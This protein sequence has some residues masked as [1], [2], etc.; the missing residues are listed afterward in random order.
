MLLFLSM[1]LFRL[2]RQKKYI[3]KNVAVLEVGKRVSHVTKSEWTRKKIYLRKLDN[4]LMMDNVMKW[5]TT[6]ETITLSET[7]TKKK[8]R[9][10]PFY[11]SFLLLGKFVAQLDSIMKFL[12]LSRANIISIHC[13][14]GMNGAQWNERRKTA[15]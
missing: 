14:N 8:Q 12:K 10:F 13:T 9:Y 11:A 4:N 6:S 7:T 5:T 3:R 15:K 1:I 2:H